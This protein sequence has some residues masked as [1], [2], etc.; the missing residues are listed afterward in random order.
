MKRLVLRGGRV[1][2][3]AG[4]GDRVADLLLAAG[5]IAACEP[6]GALGP[7]A[8]AELVDC[9]GWWVMPGLIDPHV[10]LRDPGFPQK[11]TIASGL[12]AA[13]AGGFTAVAAMANTAP[14]NDAPEITR[15]MLEQARRV[16]AAR[17][18][19]VS[20]VTRNLAGRELVDAAAMV[21]AGARLFSDDGIPIDN[22]AVLQTALRM[23]ARLDR[24]ISLHEEDRALT[25]EG[26]MNAG[27]VADHLGLAGIPPSAESTRVRR[28]LALARAAGAG[29]HIA[30]ISTAA[31]LE[32]VRAARRD[33]LAVTCEATP[34]HFTLDDYAVLEF[35]VN[36]K[37]SPPLRAAGDRDALRAALADGTID[38]IATDHAPHDPASKRA[39]RLG[40]LFH[41]GRAAPRLS[42]ADAH[43]MATAANG[44]VGLET[45]L[46]LALALVRQGLI[47]PARLVEL[48]AVNPARLL[49]LPLAGSLA[50]GAPAD[51]TVVDPDWAWTVDPAAF[52]S[53]SHN[54]PYTGMKLKGIAMLT[55]VAGE[56]IHD[57]R[58]ARRL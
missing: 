11:E 33:G 45:A 47:T 16:R 20:A 14:V 39:D 37:M 1:I 34:H 41:P 56:I 9:A 18:V 48:M 42:P 24:A 25:A 30:H 15:Y 52:R 36:A 12:A 23:F 8:D 2:D 26:A 53:R 51:V 58:G 21:A 44:I 57:A 5:Q 31:A 38:M 7:V 40:P 28:D 22:E 10:H 32:L 35:G 43:T 27:A 49:R 4:H 17:L 46:G 54:M 29:V 6:P 3:P 13:A 50:S 19:P 55:I